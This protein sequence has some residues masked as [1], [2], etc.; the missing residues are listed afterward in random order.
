MGVVK[1]LFQAGA[2]VSAGIAEV[3]AIS[4]AVLVQLPAGITPPLVLSYNATNVAVLRLGLGGKGFSEQ[5]L[6]D[7]ALNFVRPQLVTV[8]G[9][10]V[11]YPYGGKHRYVQVNLDYLAMQALGLTAANVISA[12]KAQT[13][14][15]PPGP[16]TL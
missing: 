14:F 5:Q 10:S 4:Q 9:A 7:Y 1:I 11:P 15:R 12:L 16:H 2:D 6:N 13:L 3:T 8:P